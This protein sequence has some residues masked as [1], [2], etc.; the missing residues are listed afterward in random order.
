[1]KAKFI[2]FIVAMLLTHVTHAQAYHLA[3][4]LGYAQSHMRSSSEVEA[5]LQS[6]NTFQVA[7]VHT[8][9]PYASKIGF[10]V[11]TGYLLKGARVDNESLDYHLHFLSIPVLFDMY[12]T[13]GLKLGIGPE[14]NFL[15]D[16]R[17][18]A[19]DGSSFTLQNTYTN[20]WE[21]AG[22]INASYAINF[23]ADVGIRYGHGLK[24]LAN[25]D[26]HLGRNRIRTSSLQ[27]YLYIKVAN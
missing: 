19:N 6:R 12:P 4:R 23:Y 8:H 2:I 15:L 24:T 21:L 11:E 7:L 18:R 10:S 3:L 17:N 16:G 20:R 5:S 1:M 25:R 22:V 26:V 27:F 13:K 14:V 9:K